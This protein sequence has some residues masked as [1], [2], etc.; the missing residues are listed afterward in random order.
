MQM[1]RKAC[2][3]A[4]AVALACTAW[5]GPEMSVQSNGTFAEPRLE[6]PKRAPFGASEGQPEALPDTEEAGAGGEAIVWV[7][8]AVAGLSLLGTA[9]A[10]MHLSSI[11]GSDG[12]RRRSFTVW[13]RS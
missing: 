2:V 13:G 9:G 10:A 1:W 7:F 6:I 5:A 8:G 4:G 11:T 12:R 3:A